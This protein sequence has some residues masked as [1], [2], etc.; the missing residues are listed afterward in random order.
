MWGACPYALDPYAG[1]VV[2]D[3]DTVVCKQNASGSAA[4]QRGVLQLKRLKPFIEGSRSTFV[5]IHPEI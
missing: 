5:G 2:F 3:Q 4:L 1:F